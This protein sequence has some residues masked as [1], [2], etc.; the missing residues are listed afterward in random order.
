MPLSPDFGSA[1]K[2]HFIIIIKL[3]KTSIILKLTQVLIFFRSEAIGMLKSRVHALHENL[4]SIPCIFL[5]LKTL[6]LY[7]HRNSA[8]HKLEYSIYTRNV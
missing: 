5:K 7:H 3:P 1:H 2:K 8:N 6:R 4:G